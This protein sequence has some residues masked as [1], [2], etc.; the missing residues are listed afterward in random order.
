MRGVGGRNTLPRLVTP[1]GGLGLPLELEVGSVGLLRDPLIA[2][3]ARSSYAHTPAHA[4]KHST[5]CIPTHEGTHHNPNNGLLVEPRTHTSP[6]DAY[7]T[8]SNG[9]PKLGFGR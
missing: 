3:R 1:R 2:R 7:K 8:Q 9:A 5:N 6:L 4:P